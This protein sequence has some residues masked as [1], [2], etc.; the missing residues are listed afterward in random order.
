MSNEINEQFLNVRETNKTTGEEVT[1]I[2]TSES[3]VQVV[4]LV[5]LSV[6][7]PTL[8]STGK[9][10]TSI[11]VTD[12]SKDLKSLSFSKA[13]GFEKVTISGPRLDM[14]TDFKVWTGIISVLTDIDYPLQK[15]GTIQLPFSEFAHRCGFPRSRMKKELREKL[16][17]SLK[18]IMSTIVEF[19][20]DSGKDT[21]FVRMIQLMGESTI[22]LK[23]D[24][25]V[26]TPS[27]S[28]REVYYSEYKVL[29]KLAALKKLARKESAQALYIYLEGLPA[30][31]LPIKI[32]RLRERLN[33][34]STVGVQNSVIRK[35]LKQL[36][37]IGY[38]EYQE[39]N[40]GRD[41]QFEII[42][43]NPKLK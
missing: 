21:E 17:A 34:T 25:V 8:K 35:A 42:K 41:I 1:L 28:L 29:L 15:D 22:D 23:K 4:P 19:T 32:E 16:K 3:S 13:E 27:S 5:R 18:K 9:S 26:L 14:D 31:P 6:F 12:A 36:N 40:K 39:V 33:L 10:K 11:N 38:L 37:E 43:R 24:W 2:S 20:R 30:Q 7:V